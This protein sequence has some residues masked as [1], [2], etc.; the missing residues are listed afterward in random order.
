MKGAE[1]MKILLINS[2]PV[3]SGFMKRAAERAGVQIHIRRDTADID[4]DSYD[5]ICID[6]G[7]VGYEGI[8]ESLSDMRERIVL[9][10]AVASADIA[11]VRTIS[12]PFLPE[13]LEKCMQSHLKKSESTFDEGEEMKRKAVLD[14]QEVDLIRRILDGESMTDESGDD[15]F[16][17]QRSD[18]RMKIDID[19][20]LELI[21]GVKMK[22]LRKLLEGAEIEISVK[23]PKGEG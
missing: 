13:E 7:I 6:D 12:K 14:E 22:R 8:I 3:V 16:G 18:K 17:S 10:A 9:F 19:E 11:E 5:L 23:F 15:E 20:L 21:N 4:C 2:N 1:A